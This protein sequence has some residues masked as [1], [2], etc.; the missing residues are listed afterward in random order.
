MRLVCLVCFALASSAAAPAADI[1]GSWSF[2]VTSPQGEHGSTLVVTQQGEK[3]TGAFQSDRG[4][5][6]IDGTVKD[7]QIEFFVRYTGDD[8]PPSIPF[9]GKIEGPD[10]M[11]GQ[12]NAGDVTGEWTAAKIKQARLPSSSGSW[13]HRR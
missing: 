3:I 13:A 6:K 10:K 12:Y 5:F 11:R 2:K 4:E 8:A 9:R 1:T 7:D